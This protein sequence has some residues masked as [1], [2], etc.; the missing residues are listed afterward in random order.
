MK[1]YKSSL[2]PYIV[3]LIKQK[4]ACGY[5][6]DFDA[7]I[8]QAF[9]QFCIEQHHTTDTITRELLMQWAIQRPTEGKNHRNRRMSSICQLALY[10]RSFGKNA[11]VPKH[12]ASETVDV[13]H[14]LSREELT[15]FFAAADHYMPQRANLRRF[16]LMYRVLF[17]LFYCCG[18]RLSEG[19]SLRRSCVDLDK[20]TIT[21]L[22]SKGD[23][24]RLVFLSDDVRAM[25]KDYDETMQKIVPD[26]E[27]FFPGWYPD[28]P[29]RLFSVDKKFA[30]F[31]NK[32]PFATKGAKNK[33]PTVH[34]LRHLFVVN[35]MNEWMEAGVDI[36]V[37]MPYLSRYLGH[38]SISHTQYYFHTIEQIFP[39]IRRSDVVAQ[40]V[41]PE[42]VPYE[43]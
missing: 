24:D 20:G 18:L 14:L 6:Y 12:F 28:R 35:K 10:I 15:S 38:S 13:P 11:Y 7:Y 21:I 25:C 32:T 5:K 33:K 2:A 37:M 41:I 17:R 22:Q 26:R 19:C 40:R 29:I 39:A 42:V 43:E 27:W 31:W 16:A 9:D 23:K 1:E 3:G 8:L 34:G 30:E 4:Q 36:G